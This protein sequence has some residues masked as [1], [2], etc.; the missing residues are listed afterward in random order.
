M[1]PFRLLVHEKQDII[2]YIKGLENA[3]TNLK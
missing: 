1:P 2:M 3:K